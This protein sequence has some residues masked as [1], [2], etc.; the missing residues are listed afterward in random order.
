MGLKYNV[1][2]ED[3]RVYGCKA[4][5]THLSNY[6]DIISRQ[7]RGQHGKAYL[8]EKV[9]NVTE[10]NPENRTMTTG[11]HTVRDIHCRHCNACVGWKYDHAYEPSEKYKEGK[12]ILEVELLCN[13]K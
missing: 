6:H 5:N 7:F 8:F 4:C 9:V 13:V 1:F 2:L 11:E 10:G 3:S 12:Y